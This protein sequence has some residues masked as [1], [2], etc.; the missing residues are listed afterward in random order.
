MLSS[1]SCPVLSQPSSLL[2]CI[3]GVRTTVELSTLNCGPDLSVLA[4][5]APDV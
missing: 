4:E 5:V 1:N 2:L 3:T